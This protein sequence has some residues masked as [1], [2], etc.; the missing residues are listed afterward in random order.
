[1]P[2][3]LGNEQEI[4]FRNLGLWQEKSSLLNRFNQLETWAQARPFSNGESPKG[5]KY[6]I[7]F[8]KRDSNQHYFRGKTG[9]TSQE[10]FP[11]APLALLLPI[12]AIHGRLLLAYR[13]AHDCL[14]GVRS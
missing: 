3:P 12:G 13:A 5:C 6:L 2:Q 1:M 11:M 10:G 7:G 9:T 14:F 8:R 4:L